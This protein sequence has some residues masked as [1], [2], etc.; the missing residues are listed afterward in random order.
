MI[1]RPAGHHIS[2]FK[3]ISEKDYFRTATTIATARIGT[4]AIFLLKLLQQES[5]T[6]LVSEDGNGGSKKGDRVEEDIPAT[7]TLI[8]EITS[9]IFYGIASLFKKY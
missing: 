2:C 1:L 6:A 7:G 9:N 5:L 4:M 8:E 3:K